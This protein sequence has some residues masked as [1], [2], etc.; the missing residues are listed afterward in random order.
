[1][2][3]WFLLAAIPVFGLCVLVHEFGH[4]I[5]A[6]WAG[7]RVE[8]FG[9]GFP[10]RLVGFRKRDGGGWEVIWFGGKRNAEDTYDTQKQSPFSGTSGGAS[11]VGASD[12]TIY[13]IN[14]LPIGGF[15]RMPG[16]NGDINDPEGNYDPRSFAAKSAGKRL[17][18]LVAGVTMNVLLAMVLF[19]FAFGFGE[20]KLLPQIGKVVPASPAAIAGIHPGDTIVSINNQPIKFFSDLVTIVGNVI[21]ADNNQHATV[22]ISVQIK[23]AGSPEIITTTVNVREH[24]PAGQGAMGIVASGKVVFDSIPLWQAPIRG[25]QYTFDQTSGFIQAIGQ[26]IR[27]ALPF[28]VVG[29]VGIVKI[30]GEVAASVPDLG[31]WPILSLTAI[32]SLNLAIVN[33]L[34]FPALDGG[35]VI[36]VLIEVLRG[37]KR[38]KP[39]VEGIINFAGMLMLLTL[40]VVITFF[41]VKNLLP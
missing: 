24:P 29:P 17:I 13:S 20:P 19:T 2:N 33:I 7:I 25:V 14:F 10:P 5:T 1:M 23:R 18:V 6:K 38:L 35:R 15:V 40:M 9:I 39:E 12:H 26:M 30:T 32:L 34:P 11:T 41:D 36:L 4:F 3:N 22:P 28:Q 16:E 37:G 8:E 31:W 27:G 21:K